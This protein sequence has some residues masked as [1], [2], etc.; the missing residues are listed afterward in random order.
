MLGTNQALEEGDPDKTL[1]ALQNG[2][3]D[4]SEVYP[5]NKTYYH[6]GLLARK[7]RKAHD[8]GGNLTEEEIQAVVREMNDKA[9]HDR[10]GEL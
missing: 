10:N 8:E 1:E 7:Q 5:E 4:L 9:M 3:L 2:A 6:E